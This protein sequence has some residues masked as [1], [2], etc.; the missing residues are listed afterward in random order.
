MRKT[1]YVIDGHAQIFRSYYAPFR[2]L[3]SPTTGEPTK[4]IH[5]FCATLFNWITRHKPDYLAMA[6]DVSDETVFR[7]DI[8]PQ[9]KAH[10]DPAPEDL[11]PQADRIIQIV[12]AMGVPILKKP[13]FEADDLMATLAHRLAGD[14]VDLY[15]VSR[16]KDLE[17]LITDRVFLFDPMKDEVIDRERL[18]K[19]KGYP[20]DKSVEIQIL[21]GDSVDNIRGVVGIGPKTAAKLIDKYGSASAVIEH[22]NEL[23][24]K[25]R[26]NV[27]AFAPNC[28]MTRQLVTLRR[29]VEFDFDL[30]SA[31]FD[32]VDVDAVM[33]LFRELGFTRLSEQLE[34]FRRTLETHTDTVVPLPGTNINAAPVELPAGSKSMHDDIVA[35]RRYEIVDNETKLQALAKQLTGQPA[36]AVDTE[37]TA[38]NPVAA[39]IVG[40]SLGWSPGRAYY[41]PIR[42]AVGEIIPIEVVQRHLGSIF[43]DPKITKIGQNIKYD[44]IVLRRA[45][46]PLAGPVFD[47]MI[48]SFVLEPL[49]RSHGIDAL[50]LDLLGFRKIATSELIGKGRDQLTMD[51]LPVNQIAEYACEDADITWRLYETLAPRINDSPSRLL[52][53]ETEMPLAPVLATMEEN[54][55]A[56]DRAM[57]ARMGNELA[58]RIMELTAQIHKAAGHEFNIDSPK[59]LARVLFD[60]QGLKPV[61]RTKTGP[62]TD[63]DS[64]QRLAAIS[65]HPI[66]NMMLEYRELTKLRGTYVE[67]LPKMVC[68]ATGRIHAGF[69]Q[70]GA[71]TGR[72]SSSDPNLQ[73]I[74]IRTDMGR[75][76]REAFVAGSNDHVLIVADYSQIE[77]RIMAHFSKDAQLLEAFESGQDIHAFVAAQVNNVALDQV[78]SKQRSAAKAVNF[79]IIYGQTAFGLARSLGISRTE[80]TDFIHKYFERYPGIQSFIDQCIAA[81]EINGYVETILGRRRPLPEIKSRNQGLQAL[82]KRLAVNTVIQGSAADLIKR[83][84]IDIDDAI[85]SERLDLKMLIQVH[86]ELVLESS[87]AK[88]DEH[89]TLVRSKME[90]AMTLDVPIAVDVGIGDNWLAAK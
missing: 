25:Q 13:G 29:D 27:L 53:E 26:E 54:G 80:A 68:A 31:R 34:G 63:A 32:G 90:S 10:R 19:S 59:Q 36:F 23:T 47:T 18:I 71:V 41:V 82:S 65:D 72:L 56:I 44:W 15:L 17:Q 2:P 81:A 1:F 52:F 88:A 50:A 66:C 28:E 39:S 87:R 46:L 5:V 55:V 85:Q 12:A 67:T 57:L 6:L 64:L 45:G 48:A 79:G 3:T 9:Y 60:E 49:R 43:A 33:P 74:P 30:P 35:E 70:T 4:A 77:L 86:D 83:A 38:I 89:A 8:D 61:K 37:T 69:H 14:D 75:R 40:I 16:D 78:T 22:A 11:A 73:N 24:P 84:M 62:S 58:D 76:I 21:T 20:P 51:M 42:A 7:R